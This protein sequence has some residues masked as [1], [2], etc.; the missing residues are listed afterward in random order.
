M[1][2]SNGTIDVEPSRVFYD[3]ILINYRRVRYKWVKV[4]EIIN[5]KHIIIID[6]IYPIYTL[7]TKLTL[8]Y[9]MKVII[10]DNILLQVHCVLP[11][12]KTSKAHTLCL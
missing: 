5:N 2:E 12:T 10:I 8:S 9:S 1:N 6:E 7:F 3:W 11:D 4:F